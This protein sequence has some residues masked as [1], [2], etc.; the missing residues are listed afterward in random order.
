MIF[1]KYTKISAGKMTTWA[2]VTDQSVTDTTVTTTE[3]IHTLGSSDRSAT[4]VSNTRVLK[5]Q[6][7]TD[8][9][10]EDLEVPKEFN[11]TELLQIRIQYSTK[12]WIKRDGRKRKRRHIRNIPKYESLD[13]TVVEVAPS[14][15]QSKLDAKSSKSGISASSLKGN[16]PL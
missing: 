1:V 12:I 14:L 6:N 10:I 3:R 4:G 8:S 11:E 15:N 13:K 7:G 9:S 2:Q 16:H 5:K